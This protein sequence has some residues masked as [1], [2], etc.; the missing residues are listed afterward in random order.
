MTAEERKAFQEE[1]GVGGADRDAL[2]RRILDVS[3]Q[4]T[5]FTAGDKEVRTWLL[6][7]GGTAVEAAGS[8][9][10]DLARGFIRA[11]IM[12]AADLI[13]L[14]SEREVKAKHLVRQEPKDYP[15]KDDDVL[16]IRFSV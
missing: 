2:V 15:V 16:L 9:H 5:F 11:E 1:M 6:H 12:S 4:M 14:G 3:G 8:I 7:K 10:T 13:R